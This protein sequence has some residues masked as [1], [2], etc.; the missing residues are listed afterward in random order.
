MRVHN[1]LHLHIQRSKIIAKSAHGLP[2][3]IRAQYTSP[4]GTYISLEQVVMFIPFVVN[5]ITYCSDVPQISL[6]SYYSV[7]VYTFGVFPFLSLP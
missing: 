5:I 1:C 3:A 2:M 6:P 4:L 7:Y